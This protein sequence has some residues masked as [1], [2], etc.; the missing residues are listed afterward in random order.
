MHTTGGRSAFHPNAFVQV[1][2]VRLAITHIIINFLLQSEAHY[3][4][5]PLMRT[6]KIV[7]P[8]AEIYLVELHSTDH[9]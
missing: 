1:V 2:S 8:V 5:F 4:G 7:R 3:S 9:P 6:Q